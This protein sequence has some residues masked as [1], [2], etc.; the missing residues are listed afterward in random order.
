MEVLVLNSSILIT[1]RIEDIL[2][3]ESNVIK[4]Y[5]TNSCFEAF[6]KAIK[7]LPKILVVNSI[8]SDNEVLHLLIDI[9]NK[10]INCKIIMLLNSE[11]DFIVQLYKEAGVNYFLDKYNEFQ[12]L[13]ILINE[14]LN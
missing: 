3:K 12:K 10:K 9:K 14:I 1:D 6:I 8:S 7:Y 2:L 5:K 4:L 13:P 11:N